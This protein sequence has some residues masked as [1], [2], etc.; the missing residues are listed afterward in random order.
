MTAWT[1]G[2]AGT[3]KAWTLAGAGLIIGV[4]A[5]A[6]SCARAEVPE[7]GV[8]IQKTYPHD[9]HAF[10]EGL[11]YQ[12]GFL[13]ESTGLEGHSS[14]RKVRL[15]TGQ[16][17]QEHDLDSKYF[18]EGIVIWK[19]RLIALTYTTEI[20]FIYDLRTF[21]QISDFHYKGE[22]WALTKDATHLFM[23]DGTSDLRVLDPDTL[24][25]TASIHVTC[26]GR[27]VQ[28]L[29]E[30]EWVKGEIYANIWKTPAIARIDPATGHVAGLI[31]VSELA[32][33]VGVGRTADVPNG[34]AYDAKGDRLFVTGKFW[35][36]LYQIT[37]SRRSAG[38]DLC[39]ALP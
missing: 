1:L 22:G 4:A 28:N 23:S 36:S 26:D 2:A 19:N 15:A 34:I 12:D 25:Q 13:Y 27:P 18:G 5:I 3:F 24:A 20:G 35:P 30:L 29:N 33:R 16:V 17:L 7:Y 21:R 9:P 37:L 39:E 6:S 38:Q 10:T 32:T 8:V 11:L 14:I 31:D